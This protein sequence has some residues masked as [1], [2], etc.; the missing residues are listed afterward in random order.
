MQRLLHRWKFRYHRG[1]RS[2]GRKYLGVY[3]HR[4]LR[5]CKQQRILV[6]LERR[7]NLDQQRSHCAVNLPH[8]DCSGRRKL[9]LDDG[10]F[11]GQLLK[12]SGVCVFLCI[13]VRYLRFSY[14]SW[15]SVIFSLLLLPL[16]NVLL[17]DQK[18]RRTSRLTRRLVPTIFPFGFY[19]IPSLRTYI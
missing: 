5:R 3:Q 1:W 14:Q 6:C 13:T 9:K 16:R 10:W 18:P 17:Y 19:L 11:P 2:I 4:S 7:G 15:L 12:W 8:L